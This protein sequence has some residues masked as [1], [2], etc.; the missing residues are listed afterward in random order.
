VLES[1]VRSVRIGLRLR[2]DGA[3]TDRCKQEKT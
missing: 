2:A 3:V 1:A